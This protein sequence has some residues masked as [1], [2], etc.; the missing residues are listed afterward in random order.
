MSKTATVHLFISKL[1]GTCNTNPFCVVSVLYKFEAEILIPCDLSASCKS[2]WKLKGE[3]E[4]GA[5]A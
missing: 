3:L 5:L 2:K 1:R 4:S